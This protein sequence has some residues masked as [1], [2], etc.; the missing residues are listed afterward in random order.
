MYRVMIVDDEYY[1][2]R[3]ICR[4]IDWEAHGFR[5]GAEIES[6]EKAEEYLK[7][8]EA[9]LAIVDISMPD[10]SGL[11]LIERIRKKNADI[12]III[13]TG[14]DYFEYAKRA[15]NLGV[16]RFMLKPVD[17]QELSETVWKIREELDAKQREKMEVQKL[18]T[19]KNRL[20]N[21][22]LSQML[23]ENRGLEDTAILQGMLGNYGIE[24]DSDYILLYTGCFNPMALAS[25]SAAD[26][27]EE[28]GTVARIRNQV[29]LNIVDK[30]NRNFWVAEGENA[31]LLAERLEKEL[32]KKKGLKCGA[33]DFKGGSNGLKV[34]SKSAKCQSG[35][36]EP[37]RIIC[38]RP[39][40]GTPEN[41]CRAY[42]VIKKE[43]FYNSMAGRENKVCIVC[44]EEKEVYGKERRILKVCMENLEKNLQPC[45]R[46]GILKAL[47]EFFD[48]LEGE[49]V[50]LDMLDVLIKRMLYS[51]YCMTEKYLP[52]SMYEEMAEK[53][54]AVQKAFLENGSI[55]KCRQDMLMLFENLAGKMDTVQHVSAD[56]IVKNVKA[57]VEKQYNDKELGVQRIAETLCLNANYVGITF[58]RVMGISISQYM[59]QVRMENAVFLI[60]HTVVPIQE[61]AEMAGYSD[62]FYFSKKFKQLYGMSPSSYRYS[63]N[64]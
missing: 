43:L 59:N 11:E 16:S 22:Y 42:A 26:M 1:I 34:Q 12:K 35:G 45:N 38:S 9:D 28:A 2:R 51:A 18:C 64:L 37:E 29:R 7:Q 10:I 39:F 40:P 57:I 6:G 47:E 55:R 15:V 5:V 46:A 44:S 4:C 49:L 48:V 23:L 32:E 19:D 54:A 56:Q 14:Y 24:K 58:K 61:I 25:H 63:N 31:V 21:A 8:N 20:E 13:L 17:R 3:R 52:D 62:Q 60:R 41:I 33:K 30:Y 53:I 50:S 27:E 36:P